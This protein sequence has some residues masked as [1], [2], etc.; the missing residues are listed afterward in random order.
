MKRCMRC[1]GSVL[2]QQFTDESGRGTCWTCIACGEETELLDGEPIP[3]KAELQQ[4]FTEHPLRIGRPPK[5]M[6]S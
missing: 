5:R 2:G 1:H 3:S 6:I 4:I